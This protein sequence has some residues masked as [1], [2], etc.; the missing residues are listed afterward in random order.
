MVAPAPDATRTDATRVDGTRTAVSIADVLA[1]Q[2]RLDGTVVRTPVGEYPDVDR[3]AGTTVVV[4]HEN[5][6]RTGAFK[7]RGASNLLLSM[8]DAE[9]ARGVVA[10]STGNHAQGVAYAARLTGTA[11][12]I[13]MPDDPNP[14]KLRAV[15]DLGADVLLHGATFDDARAQ[16]TALAAASGARLVGAANEPAII[17]GVG[18]LYLELFQQSPGLDVLV[19]PVG[20]GSGAAAASLVASAVAPGTE[21][22]GVQSS[23]SPAAHDSWH[24]GTLLERANTTRAEGLAVGCG[25]EITQALMRRHLADFVLVTDEQISDAQQLYL[26]GAHTVAEGAGAAALAAVLADPERFAG[27]RVGVVCTGGNA[28]GDELRRALGRADSPGA[29]APTPD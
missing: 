5:Q 10:Y 13:V 25:F 4:K 9:R 1:A 23:A 28:S 14:V 6:Q 16:A 8:S 17:A 29:D 22:I 20:G 21:V 7:A 11:C 3:A 18:S 24:A 27:R 26:T 12:T 19:V 15:L 2:S